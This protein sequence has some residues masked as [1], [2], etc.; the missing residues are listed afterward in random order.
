MYLGQ[1]LRACSSGLGLIITR[2]TLKKHD[3]AFS[4]QRDRVSFAS[5]HP[6]DNQGVLK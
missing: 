2:G 4:L 3:R 6:R 5:L 1:P